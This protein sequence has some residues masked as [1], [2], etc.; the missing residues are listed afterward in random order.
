L[1]R[2][3]VISVT[4]QSDI[5]HASFDARELYMETRVPLLKGRAAAH[6]L[7]FAAGLRYSRF[8][9][10][11]TDS[12][13]QTG[14]NWKPVASWSVRASYAQVFRVPNLQ[15]LYSAQVKQ[16]VEN[17]FDPCGNGPTTAQQV[18]CAANG[19]PGGAYQED[20][21]DEWDNLTGGNS[22]L[23]PERGTSFD[24]GIEFQPVSW[25][26]VKVS[27]DFF[28]VDLHGF[29]EDPTPSDVLLECANRGTPAVC[30]LIHRAP[31]GTLRQIDTLSS[32]FGRAVSS[33]YDLG[34]SLGFDARQTHFNAGLS[35]T[36]LARRDTQA[37]VGGATTRGAG[38]FV[39]FFL[40]FP[41]WRGNAYIEAR[42]PNW[43]VSYSLQYIGPYA[44]CGDGE[45][46]LADTDCY[47]I[48]SR[49]YH[50]VEGGFIVHSGFE[51]RAGITNLTN[52]MPPFVDNSNGNTVVATYRLLGRTYFAGIR[53][54]SE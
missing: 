42:R 23:A 1:G 2:A 5:E 40:S 46:Y 50:D 17:S 6:Q 54:R 20:P 48:A 22:K 37:Y 47:G 34:A 16:R 12:T 15:E 31:D 13:W 14:I 49:I 38:Q 27:V 4:A 7:D 9:S 43:H 33:G 8:S 51:L 35:A 18:D 44:G 39:D 32:N 52:A 24:A 30:A 26:R 3:G 28:N 36:Y 45:Q 21:L 11:G 10:F 25:P 29:I 19:V 41:H 53:Y